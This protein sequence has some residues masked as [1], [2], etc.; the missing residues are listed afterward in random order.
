[1]YIHIYLKPL[2]QNQNGELGIKYDILPFF[3]YDILHQKS[4]IVQYIPFVNCSKFVMRKKIRNLYQYCVAGYI[5]LRNRLALNLNL[6]HKEFDISLYPFSL[7]GIER[8]TRYT[9]L[10]KRKNRYW[11]LSLDMNVCTSSMN[12]KVYMFTSIMHTK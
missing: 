7:A 6:F 9:Y 4:K 11:I 3:W 10:V 2:N 1:M 5:M 12:C 8:R